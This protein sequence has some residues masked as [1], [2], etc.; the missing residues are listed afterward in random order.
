MRTRN[1]II[2][3]NPHEPETPTDAARTP[4]LPRSACPIIAINGP[5]S[6]ACLPIVSGQVVVETHGYFGSILNRVAV[7]NEVGLHGVELGISCG[8]VVGH[9]KVPF[10]MPL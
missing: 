10:S 9:R 5:R 6:R 8:N 7:G 1:P 3:G 4:Y 2:A